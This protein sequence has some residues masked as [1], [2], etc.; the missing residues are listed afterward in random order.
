MHSSKFER[1]RVLFLQ[2]NNELPY[3]MSFTFIFIGII[4]IT[5]TMKEENAYESEDENFSFDVGLIYGFD[6]A[7]KPSDAGVNG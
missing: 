7:V 5:N 6:V 2:K 3:V 1:A 4:I